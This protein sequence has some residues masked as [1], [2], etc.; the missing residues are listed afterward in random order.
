[1]SGTDYDDFVSTLITAAAATTGVTFDGVDKHEV[2]LSVKRRQRLERIPLDPWGSAY[3][4]TILS[5]EKFQIISYGEDLQEGTEDDVVWPR[6][7]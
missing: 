3:D 5:S 4:Y 7:E 2:E 6:D 1:M